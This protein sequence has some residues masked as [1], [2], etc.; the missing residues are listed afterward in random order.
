MKCPK[1]GYNSFE[2]LELCKKC[3]LALAEHKA[4]FSLRGFFFAG[5]ATAA[6]ATHSATENFDESDQPED[7]AVDFGFDFL[8]EEDGQNDTQA[9]FADDDESVD[10]DQPF[11]VDSESVPADTPTSGKGGKGSEFAF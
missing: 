7:S 1:C 3:G 5:Q 4:K 9:I 10:I 8:D 2:H 6:A 11:G